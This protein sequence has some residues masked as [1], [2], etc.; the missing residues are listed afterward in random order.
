MPLEV[1]VSRHYASASET[2]FDAWLDPALAR[3]FLFA[4][5]SGK[6]VRVE[7]DPRV[8]GGF[9]IVEMRDGVEASHYGVYREIS[10]P[11][12]IVFDFS[13]EAG[14]AGDPVEIDIAARG[15]GCELVLTTAMKPAY[16]QYVERARHGWNHILAALARTLGEGTKD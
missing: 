13:V 8:G 9:T 15:G 3:R 6:M 10:R 2:V 11:R 1:R 4:T 7:I 14:V 12:R 5:D 16:A